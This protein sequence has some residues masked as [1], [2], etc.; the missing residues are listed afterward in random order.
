M[1]GQLRWGI[2]GTGN[3]AKQFAGGVKTSKRGSIV[4]VGSRQEATAREFA[5]KYSIAASYGGYGDLLEDKNVDAVYISLP[6]SMHHEWTLEAINHGKHVLCEKPIATNAVQAEEMFDAAQA[7][8]VKLV[9]AFMYRSHPVTIQAAEKVRAGDIGQLKMV[10]TSF[11]YRTN[12]IAGNIRFDK[13]LYGGALMDIGCYC[14]NLS[15]LLAGQE[16]E[17]MHAVAQ[18]HLTGVDE[19]TAGVLKFPNGVIAS[20]TCGMSLQVDNTAY[21]SGTDGYLEIP[22]PWKPAQKGASYTLARSTPPKMD[23]PTATTQPTPPRQQFEVDAPCDLFGLEAD[24]FAATVFDNAPPRITR[25][26]SVGNM[27]VLD[28]LRQQVGV[29]IDENSMV[30]GY[31]P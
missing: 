17:A 27:R 16:P 14:I 1:A 8:G 23:S 10:R 4:A 30:S 13:S 21:I 6:N 18:I 7:K 5:G 15:R 2:L 31:T 24:D 12:K 28:E 11:C 20:F 9:E 25:T 19:A 22:V 29:P 26:D 3:I